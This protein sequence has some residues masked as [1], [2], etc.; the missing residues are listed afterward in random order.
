MILRL[1]TLKNRIVPL[2]C[3][4][5]LGIVAYAQNFAQYVNPFI[6]TGGHGHTFP[7]AVAPFG[8][9][10]L[11]PDTRVDGSWDGCSG[12]HY[13]DSVIY[14]F[15]HTHLSGTGCTDWGDILL[16]PGYDLPNLNN[17]NYSSRF[18]HKNE[19]AKA[20]YYSVKLNNGVKAELTTTL[21]TGIHQYTFLKNNKPQV[22]LDLLHRDETLSQNVRLVDSNT[23]VGFRISKAWAREQYIFFAIKFSQAIAR[24]DYAVNK[25]FKNQLNVKTKEKPEGAIFE[26]KD[27]KG[28]PLIVKVGISLVSEEG[29]LANLNAE[30]PHWEFEKYVKEAGNSWNQE[31]SKI[32]VT[33]ENKDKLAIFY[34]S[35]YHC[36]IHP[37]IASDVDE[38]Y[39]G[40]DNKIHKA[41][42]Y[43]HYTVFSLWD[44]YRAL[45][46]LLTIIDK[47]RTADFINTFI[48]QYEQ[49][50]RFPM[51]ELSSNETDCM[52]GYHSVSVVADVMAKGIKGFDYSKAFEGSIATSKYEK[53]GLPTFNKNSFL[54]VEDESESVSKT[55]EYGYNNYCVYKIAEIVNQS[56]N[57]LP[58]YTRSFAFLNLLH[59]KSKFMQPRYNGGWLSPFYPNQINNHFT[60]GNSWQYSFY[61]PHQVQHLINL[62]GGPKFF[63]NKLDELFTT[64]Q[65][66]IGREQADVTGL[67]GQYA[68]GNEPSHHMAYLYNYINKPYKTIYYT[69]KIGN[70]FYKNSPDGLIGNEDCGQMSAWY[71][72]NAL[73]FYP[74]CPGE[75]NYQLSLPYF[76]KINIKLENGNSF[77]IE[78]ESDVKEYLNGVEVNGSL[79]TNFNLAHDAIDKGGK[80][81]FRSNASEIKRES[82]IKNLV[83]TSTTTLLPLVAPVIESNLKV[84]ADKELVKMVDLNSNTKQTIRYTTNGSEPTKNSTIYI[85]PFEVNST[86]IIK[87]K[88]FSANDSSSVTETKLFKLPNNFKISIT[89]TVNPQYKAMGP[90]TLLDGLNGPLDWRKGE[91]LGYQGQ[92]IEII[93]DMLQSQ[94]ISEILPNFLQDSKSWILMPKQAECLISSDN[95]TFT[96][97]GVK[98]TVT[99]PKLEEIVTESLNFQC[100][101]KC[102]YIKLKITHFGK[103]PEWHLGNSNSAFFFIDEIKIK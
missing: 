11:S 95:K 99:N 76:K 73:G 31:L 89:G 70:E 38:N 23:V 48:S 19:T 61:V 24:F 32:E 69:H 21:R 55:L 90:S 87:A 47:K 49:C 102:R 96:T 65:K 88:S 15:S 103:L 36:F 53:Y 93:I 92:D 97:L 6:G 1:N 50:G 82:Y 45:H 71:V 42:N 9:V 62:H 74:V 68:H 78:C 10:Q 84:F 100:N 85:K 28:K 18:S 12:Y 4:L 44:T 91:W 81:I 77:L 83:T 13:S 20:G 58:Y 63:E 56:S 86:C 25:Q 17:L 101:Q 16:M 14:G 57:Y 66:T 75:T 3:F 46:P 33:E 59:P 79:L 40:R 72:F 98:Q 39:R 8:M 29:A 52:I 41:Q 2:F 51:W 5:F 30:A 35:L 64:K 94:T 26:F 67:I 60:E 7:G 43:T 80:M 27:L 22:V 34:T 37:S 54:Q